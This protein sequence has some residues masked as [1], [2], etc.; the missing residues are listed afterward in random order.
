MLTLSRQPSALRVLIVDDHELTRFSLQLALS[1][2][3]NIELVGSAS[4][5]REAIEMVKRYHPDV[6]IL[7]L[8][9]PIM[10]GWSA[11][12]HIKHI[13]PNSQIIAYSS[14]ETPKLGDISHSDSLD[15]F[16]CKDAATPE[17]VALVRKLGQRVANQ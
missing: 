7:D 2:Q 17:L 13:E 16:C 15:A 5:G 9:M 11:S 6:V 14:L 4:N 12:S 8:Q 1:S 3:D 10:D